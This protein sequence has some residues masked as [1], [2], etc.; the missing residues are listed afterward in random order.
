VVAP[1]V[2]FGVSTP[3]GPYNLAEVDQ[4]EA[5]A[6][7]RVGLIMYFQG[8][9]YDPF[10]TDL[11]NGVAA[12]G[13]IPEITWEPWDYTLGLNQP[14]YSLARIIDGTHDPYIT[15]FAQSAKDFGKTVFIRFAHEMN[16][17]YYPWCEGVNGN[18]T[19]GQFVSA[20][21]HVVGIF[22]SVGA[23]NVKWV[24]SPNVSYSGTT[25]L[26]QLYP[27]DAW[28]DWVALDGYNGGTALPYGG[29]QSFEQVFG[30]SLAELATVTTSKPVMIGETASVEQGGSKPDWI[31]A[32]FAQLA[33]HPEI[34][35]F[36]WFNQNKEADWRIESSDPSR[37]SF[38]TG[39]ANPRY[40]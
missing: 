6:G 24:W 8:W 34:K 21:Q 35:A 19:A 37:Q 3:S 22:R 12:R 32:K 7:K 38:A 9:P 5:D 23:T 30:P 39:V 27:G 36:V 26:A 40:G 25:P 29:W 17:N 28:V 20:W 4:F 11:A 33:I 10:R 16:T 2:L 18:Y 13:A 15:A 1:S 31:T 14:D